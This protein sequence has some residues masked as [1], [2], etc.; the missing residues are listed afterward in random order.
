MMTKRKAEQNLEQFFAD[1]NIRKQFEKRS[2]SLYWC[3][4]CDKGVSAGLKSLT[5]HIGGEKHKKILSKSPSARSNLVVNNFDVFAIKRAKVQ[6]E[7]LIRLAD[8][9]EGIELIVDNGMYKFYCTTCKCTISPTKQ[10]LDVH[11]DT[12]KH[13]NYLPKLNGHTT[14]DFFKDTHQLFTSSKFKTCV[15][16]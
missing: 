11:L 6:S 1:E 13:D 10:H 9:H 15:D 5:S 7:N 16:R 8:I 14:Y 4:V 12:E 2:E 3:I